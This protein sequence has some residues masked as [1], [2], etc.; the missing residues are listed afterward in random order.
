MMWEL[1]GVIIRL[2]LSPP[3]FAPLIYPGLVTVLVILVSLIWL[4]R[5]IAAKVQLRYGPYYIAKRLGGAPQLIA[6]AIRFMFQEVIVPRTAD[7]VPYLLAPVLA[8]TL[9]LV[10]AVFI[11][12]A[13]GFAGVPSGYSLPLA[14]ALSSL[15]PIVV[16]LMAWSANNKFTVQGGVREA[17]MVIAY[18][19]P[20]F[21]AALSM[22]LAYETLSLEEIVERQALVPGAVLNPLAAFVF[23][24]S[25]LMSAGKLPFDIVEGEQ[26]IVAGPFTEYS[27]ILYGL[28]MGAGYVQLY[29]LSMIFAE[30]FL[31][32]W[33]PFIGSLGALYLPLGGLALFVKAY[34]VLA[35]SVFLRSVYGRYRLDYALRIGWER[36]FPLSVLALF[37]SLGLRVVGV[38]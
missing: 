25:M 6:D 19:I 7:K 38:V 4:E 35:F 36:L 32:G 29:V 14:L 13:P 34:L 3:V 5:K 37:L 31:A 8:M 33:H 16:I 23:Y 30:V 27:G 22:G 26:E 12:V 2:L 15:L 20:L 17:F 21:V 28:V 10:P 24:V 11:P 9:G 1:I 18:E